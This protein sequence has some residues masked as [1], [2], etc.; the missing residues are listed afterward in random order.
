MR[1]FRPLFFVAAAFMLMPAPPESELASAGLR[2]S[3]PDLFSAAAGT[4]SDMG[5]FCARQPGVC[6]TAGYVAAHMEARAKYGVLLIYRWANE[7]QDTPIAGQAQVA[8]P[9]ATGSVK[10]IA[11]AARNTLRLEDYIPEWRGPKSLAK[12]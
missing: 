10:K 11:S 12:G 9:M 4:V 7:A 3:A 6:E 1:L 5:S 8:D 2:V